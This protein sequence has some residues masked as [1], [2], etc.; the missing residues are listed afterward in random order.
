MKKLLDKIGGFFVTLFGLLLAV[1]L[2]ACFILMLPFDYIRYKRSYY[3]KNEHKKYIL[4]AGAGIYFDFYEVIA[5]NNLPIKYIA[6]PENDALECGWFVYNK[7]LILP[8]NTVEYYPHLDEWFF[9]EYDDDG[10]DV[11]SSPFSIDEYL[12]REIDFVN[13]L[14]DTEI[15]NDAIVLV[16]ANVIENADKARQQKNFLVFEDWEEDL[17]EFCDNISSD[18]L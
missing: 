13:E 1:V 4:F 3:Y 8:D 7:T 12:K 14:F 2:G 15:C 17:K 6:N 18:N 16:D 10:H 9:N 5:K 11:S